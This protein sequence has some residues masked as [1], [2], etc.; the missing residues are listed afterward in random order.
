MKAEVIDT[1]LTELELFQTK[2]GQT[3][4]GLFQPHHM[5]IIAEDGRHKDSGTCMASQVLISVHQN[6]W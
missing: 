2:S 4:S 6:I 3:K 1:V 5:L